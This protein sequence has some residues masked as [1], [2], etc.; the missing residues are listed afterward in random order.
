MPLWT[1]LACRSCEG[2]VGFL[3]EIETELLR[4]SRSPA[5]TKRLLA[6]AAA[7]FKRYADA[8][9]RRIPGDPRGYGIGR[10]NFE[11]LMRERLGFDWT[12][13]EALANGERL[14]SQMHYLLERE[15]ARH[16]SKDTRS[17]LDE[18]AAQ[19]T[20]QRPLLEEY[21]KATSCNQR[22]T[23]R[24]RYRDAPAR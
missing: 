12:L 15:A 11:L 24:A 17:I 2:A 3:N 9:A 8:I 20:P 13:P 18:A 22:K 5:R 7:G 1:D 10:A 19:W 14:V 6:S 21:R 4:H 23:C 16:G